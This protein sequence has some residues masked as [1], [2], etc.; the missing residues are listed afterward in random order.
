VTDI[1]AVELDMPAASLRPMPATPADLTP[2]WLTAALRA[3]GLDVV[4]RA[5]RTTPFGEG[6]GMLS[7]LVRAEL[8]YES[9]AGP[10]S[11]VVKMP[12]HQEGN[13]ATAVGFHCYERE[14]GFYMTAAA[15]TPA[16]TP[17]IYHADIEGAED[18]VLVMEDFRGYHIGDQV[19]GCTVEQARLCMTTI[20]ELHASFWSRVDDPAFDFVPYHWPSY[21]SDAMHQGTLA[22]WDRL[23]ELAGDAVPGPVRDAKERYL[24]AIPGMQEWITAE[25]RT[26]VHGDFRMDNLYFGQ[27]DGQAPLALGDWQGMVRGKGAHDIAYYLT[28]SMP[29]EPRR[30]HERELIARWHAGLAAGGVTDYSAGDAWEDY[31]R[32]ALYLWTYVVVIFG[33]LDP[34]NERGLRWMQEITR[35]SS[36]TILDLDLLE[37]LDEFV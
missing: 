12:T 18:F 4:V 37:L 24:A 31:R 8:E 28:Q 29:I 20:A 30:A 34:G 19:V 35:R 10:A 26:L 13:R 27:A 25:P 16:R 1:H 33:A 9:G 7:L 5:V 14:V 23:L 17:R 36:A 15:R 6:A 21:F 32:A 3:G 11:V 22:L 2:E